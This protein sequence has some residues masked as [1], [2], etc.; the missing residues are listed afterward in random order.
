MKDHG[1]LEKR[2]YA[3]A[4]DILKDRNGSADLVTVSRDTPIV[5][6][7]KILNKQGISQIPVTDGEQFIGSLTDSK[8][9][10]QLID[11]PEMKKTTRYRALWI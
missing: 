2:E 1:Y 4:Q 8:L 5:E 3:T 10:H 7:I 6:A 11:N 9:L